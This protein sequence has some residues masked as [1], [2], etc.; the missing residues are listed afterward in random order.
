MESV[1]KEKNAPA[2]PK[3]S[4]PK[5]T[6]DIKDTKSVKST[7][8]ASPAE[9]LATLLR[10]PSLSLPIDRDTQKADI[11]SD[12]FDALHAELK[13]LYPAVFK[14]YER[15]KV[16]RYP[17]ILHRKGQ[18]A[19]SAIVLAAHQ[20]VVPAPHTGWKYE[21]F[22]GIIAEGCIWGRGAL[23]DTGSLCA[24]MEACESLE[25]EGFIP[26]VDIYLCF[27]HNE[28]TMGWGAAAIVAELEK[29][30]V[31]P[32]FVLDEGGAVVEKP[33]PLMTGKAAMIGITEKGVADIRFCAESTGG[34]AST[35]PFKS[36][37]GRLGAFAA[38]VEKRPPFKARVSSAL[39]RM[40]CALSRRM[41]F[42]LSLLF[43]FPRFFA[44]LIR[45]VFKASGGSA[46]ALVQTSC[47]F[48]MAQ[49]SDAVNV[50][51]GRAFFTANLRIAG[52]DTVEGVLAALQKRAKRFGIKAELIRGH[53]A[54][55]ESELN[56]GWNL[57]CNALG[58]EFPD[59]PA[60][61][62]IMLAASDARHYCKICPAVYRFSPFEMN[63]AQRDSV[64]GINEH[65][66]IAN[67]ERGIRFYRELIRSL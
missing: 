25:A 58:K 36:P 59:T 18:D 32:L 7:K 5:S 60:V 55:A 64:H 48:T 53:K 42:P 13:R 40:L 27:S 14:A 50:L 37:L 35:P 62:Y 31:K 16:G 56:R 51:P 57:L 1:K 34:H 41:S 67:F 38:S 65:I 39:C 3:T 23:D 33:L 26:A 20:D 30:G 4:A 52:G 63:K 15:I 61:P 54:S 45:T 8:P 24:I 43:R 19:S 2:A 22:G 21:P 44:P 17:L 6:K 9:R 28:E 46:R 10:I 29:R 49:G 66:E 47:A 11:K 12:V